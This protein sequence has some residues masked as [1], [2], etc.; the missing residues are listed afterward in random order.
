M[1]HLSSIALQTLAITAFLAAPLAAS[2]ASIREDAKLQEILVSTFVVE[3]TRANCSDVDIR[4]N[5]TQKKIL[6]MAEHT[7]EM[8]YSQAEIQAEVASE[9]GQARLS[10]AAT[11]YMTSRGADMAD[12]ASICAFAQSEI[13]ARTEVGKLLKSR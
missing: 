8:G 9:E 1:R 5:R 11:D 6:E 12:K 2:A 10:A 7:A 3:Q 13:K 4:M